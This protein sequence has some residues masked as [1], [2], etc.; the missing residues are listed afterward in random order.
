MKIIKKGTIP[1]T[2]KRFTCLNC[3]CIFECD[4]REYK[5][6]FDQRDGDYS[7]ADCPTCGRRVLIDF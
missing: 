3:G 7:E 4:E 6:H 2:T 5:M 1:K